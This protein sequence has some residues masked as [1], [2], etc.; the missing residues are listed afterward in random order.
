LP[1]RSPGT[2]SRRWLHSA[3]RSTR[4]IAGLCK[5]ACRF[6]C[7]F[8]VSAAA[9][10]ACLECGC[11][12][13]QKHCHV[14]GQMHACCCCCCCGGQ[15]AAE[16]REPLLQRGRYC[17]ALKRSRRSAVSKGSVKLG[18]SG[19]GGLTEAGRYEQGHSQQLQGLCPYP[20]CCFAHQVLVCR[21]WG[22]WGSRRDTRYVHCWLGGGAILGGGVKV[23][24]RHVRYDHSGIAHPV[25][26]REHPHC[27]RERSHQGTPPMEYHFQI[28][29]S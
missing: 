10:T 28:E 17:V 24:C 21:V 15:G 12:D 5:V 11:A 9:R 26:E 2:S 19:T 14:H 6:V 25:F 16:G 29:M 13:L 8:Q 3:V 4:Y 22:R 1:H 20:C 27:G 7:A 23:T 18:E